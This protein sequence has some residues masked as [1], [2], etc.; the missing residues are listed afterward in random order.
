MVG[1]VGSSPIEPTNEYMKYTEAAS[2]GCLPLFCVL[3]LR[4]LPALRRPVRFH[5]PLGLH[6]DSRRVIRHYGVVTSVR[7]PFAR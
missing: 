4:E 5:F 6:A 1:V 3:A 7:L 2:I